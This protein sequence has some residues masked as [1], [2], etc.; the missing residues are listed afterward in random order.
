MKR[1][2]QYSHSLIPFVLLSVLALSGAEKSP[3]LQMSAG[4]E[5]TPVELADGISASEAVHL[6]LERNPTLVALRMGR[7]VA[8]GRVSEA[9][10]L[11][12]PELRTGRFDLDDD[13]DWVRHRNY[14]VAVRWSPPRIGERDLKGGW[15]SGRVSEVEGVIAAAEQKLAAE[16]RLL[17]MNIVFLDERI[18]LADASVKQRWRMLDAVHS[19]VEAGAN[20]VLDE[21]VAELA[22]ADARS[23]A[24]SHRLERRISMNSLA[25]KLNL[26][27]TANLDIQVDGDAVAFHPHPLDAAELIQDALV[28]RPELAMVSARCSQAGAMLALTKKERYPWFS[29]LQVNRELGGY[30]AHSWG[31]RLGVDL[32]IF[33]WKPGMIQ[34]PAAQ[35]DQCELEYEA[36]KSRIALEVEELVERL[37]ARFGELEIYA[38]QIE[39]VASRDVELSQQALSAGRSDAIQYLTAQLR[40]FRRR[41]TYLDNLLECRRLEISLDQATGNAIGK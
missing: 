1:L 13:W 3:R 10:A 4:G 24:N 15:A 14:N 20:S 35:K 9:K 40:Q 36:M 12:D 29:F 17:H 32:P 31:F 18:K 8:E 11:S 26:P 22:L 6:A 41:Q 27:R 37:R 25:G 2:I 21:T 39:P 34:A 38:Q 16:V 7:A 23:L 5:E 30:D 28:R 33:K 19:Q